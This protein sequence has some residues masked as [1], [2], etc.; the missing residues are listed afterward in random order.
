MVF[1][2]GSEQDCEIRMNGIVLEKVKIYKFLGVYL[3]SNLTFNHHVVD[4]IIPRINKKIGMIRAVTKN[5]GNNSIFFQKLF[6]KTKVQPIVEYGSCVWS[7]NLTE[8]DKHEDGKIIKTTPLKELM[9]IQV[10]YFKNSMRLVGNPCHQSILF[11]IAVE[12]IKIRIQGNRE[13]FQLKCYLR[14][15]PEE[16]DH[17]LKNQE[18][19]PYENEVYYDKRYEYGFKYVKKSDSYKNPWKTIV[20]Y[21]EPFKGRRT[22]TISSMRPK[23]VSQERDQWIKN[24][25]LSW[26]T[27]KQPKQTV[28]TDLSKNYGGPLIIFNKWEVYS[29]AEQ[30]KTYW[31]DIKRMVKDNTSKQETVNFINQKTGKVLKQYKTTWYNDVYYL[32]NNCKNI[33]IIRQLRIGCSHLVGH[34]PFMYKDPSL[35]P[36]CNSKIKEDCKHYILKCPRYNKQRSRFINSAKRLFKINNQKMTIKYILGFPT[37]IKDLKKETFNITREI[38]FG[39]LSKYIDETERFS[40][41]E[42]ITPFM[43]TGIG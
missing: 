16:I 33:R 24:N 38:I 17:Q 41:P 39:H 29:N 32:L 13:K 27:G 12:S 26:S 2:N 34:S 10:K 3:S 15:M 5:T 21:Y 43:K 4:Y 8:Y 20:T 22:K 1:G 42:W 30:A 11:D 14:M 37:D 23:Y 36:G 35:C 25:I 31:E 6:W 28:F 7:T 40:K 19:L 9:K 18:R